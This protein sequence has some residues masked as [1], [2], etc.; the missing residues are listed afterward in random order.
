MWERGGRGQGSPAGVGGVCGTS[1][2]QSTHDMH[3]TIKIDVQD[4]QDQVSV[5]T[6][7]LVHVISHRA[8]HAAPVMV[9][10]T[11]GAAAT[12]CGGMLCLLPWR[13][14]MCGLF[15]VQPVD[16]MQRCSFPAVSLCKTLR[17]G[18]WAPVGTGPTFVGT[19]WRK[20]RWAGLAS[21]SVCDLMLLSVGGTCSSC[22]LL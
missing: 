3:V 13:S 9:C 16:T 6:I 4:P 7:H 11:W 15:A 18:R 21:G 2:Q 20:M 8:G 5:C 12:H 1:S 10:F 22:I 19:G 17:Y 14:S